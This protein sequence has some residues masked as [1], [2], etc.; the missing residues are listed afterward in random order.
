[1]EILHELDVDTNRV[2]RTG[3]FTDG[4]ETKSRVG[5]LEIPPHDDGDDNTQIDENVVVEQSA[6]DHGDI[7]EERDGQIRKARLEIFGHGRPADG[8]ETVSDKEVYAKTE[9]GQ[10]KT[11]NV[12]V[13]ME[14]YRQ[15]GKQESAERAH[16]KCRE[17]SHAEAVCVASEDVTEDGTNRHRTFYTKVQASRFFNQDLACRAVQ[18]RN[19]EYHD[20][21]NK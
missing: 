2:C 11:G 5:M 18:K 14:R 1:M 19:V 21:M 8:F 12:L 13:C 10:G 4:A 15:Y 3:I 6:S 9:G 16:D 17:D 7:R 20:V